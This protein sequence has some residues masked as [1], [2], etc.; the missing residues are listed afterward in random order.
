M[1][2]LSKIKRLLPFSVGVLGLAYLTWKVDYYKHPLEK[3]FAWLF[4]GMGLGGAIG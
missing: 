2:F 3:H 1:L 4:F